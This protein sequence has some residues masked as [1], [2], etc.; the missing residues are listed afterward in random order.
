MRIFYPKRRSA[1]NAFDMMFS[2]GGR[3]CVVGHVLGAKVLVLLVFMVDFADDR[4]RDR[5]GKL[6]RFVGVCRAPFT[7]TGLARRRRRTLVIRPNDVIRA[8]CTACAIA[9]TTF[10]NELL[11]ILIRIVP[12]RSILLVSKCNC[13]STVPV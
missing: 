6:F 9:S 1:L 12:G 13:S 4:T 3:N 8:R 5:C 7:R 2:W 10:S 11:R